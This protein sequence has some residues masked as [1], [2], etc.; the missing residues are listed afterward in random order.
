MKGKSEGALYIWKRKLRYNEVMYIK[1]KVVARAKK[2]KVEEVSVD[3]LNIWVRE[4]AER[5]MANERVL[6]LIRS[7]Y[8]GK[9]IRMISGHHSPSKIISIDEL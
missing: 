4:A 8:P 6:E 2:E 3:H 5:N 1:V 9:A 7:K